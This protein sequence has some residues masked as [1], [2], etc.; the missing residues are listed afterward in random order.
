[1]KK[2]VESQGGS[3]KKGSKRGRSTIG[4]DP[5]T[6][7]ERAIAYWIKHR[8]VA[9]NEEI[10]RVAKRFGVHKNTMKDFVRLLAEEEGKK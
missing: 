5:Q 7:L 9:T 8:P 10:N 3:T 1:M 6:C 4:T 2:G